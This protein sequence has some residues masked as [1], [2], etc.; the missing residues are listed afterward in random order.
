MI[1][2]LRLAL[3]LCLALAAGCPSDP[4]FVI[5]EVDSASTE[6]STTETVDSEATTA[7]D[8][9][10]D[11]DVV[12]VLEDADV[13]D[14]IDTA[15]VTTDA[16]V[17]ADPIAPSSCPPPCGPL[18]ICNDGA[19]QC[20]SSGCE[21]AIR[22]LPIDKLA[23]AVTPAGGPIVAYT[24]FVETQTV[25]LASWNGSVFTDTLSIIRDGE[26][27]L[28]VVIDTSDRPIVLTQSEDGSAQFLWRD[29]QTSFAEVSTFQTVCHHAALAYNAA[30]QTAVIGCANP[31]TGSFLLTVLEGP[32]SEPASLPPLAIGKVPSPNVVR[33]TIDPTGLPWVIHSE[34]KDPQVTLSVARFATTWQK[35]DLGTVTPPASTTLGPPLDIAVDGLGRPHVVYVHQNTLQELVLT[36]RFRTGAEAWSTFDLDLDAALDELTTI[37]LEPGKDG[38]VQLLLVR[39]SR[40]TWAVIDGGAITHER[41][42]TSPDG[43]AVAADMAVSGSQRAPWVVYGSGRETLRLWRP[44][45]P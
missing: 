25:S 6:T 15:E 43:D 26:L 44:A 10:E 30:N 45:G 34:K 11:T 2:H 9:I 13:A 37:D 20:S 17:D 8:T 36:H 31:S 33:F 5:S 24:T 39:K 21:S 7:T 16:N 4:A 29:T 41:T 42:L 12:E 1:V 32:D 40:I 19:C 28:G 38:T 3:V 14:L 22:P 35:E 18:A 27:P 23:L